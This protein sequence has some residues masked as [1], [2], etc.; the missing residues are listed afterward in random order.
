MKQEE[1]NTEQTNE[2]G[3]VA[4]YQTIP[5]L[6]DEYQNVILKNYKIPELYNLINNYNELEKHLH[7]LLNIADDNTLKANALINLYNESIKENSKNEDDAVTELGILY[8]SFPNGLKEKVCK[9]LISRKKF[10][11]DACVKIMDG[12][13]KAVEVKGDVGRV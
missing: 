8:D 13:S 4:I 10:Y 9:E 6:R 5:R 12:F 1:V 3:M 11:E 7:G 2:I